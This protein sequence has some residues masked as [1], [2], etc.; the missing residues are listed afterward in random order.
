[1]NDF[2][3]VTSEGGYLGRLHW[4]NTNS[5]GCLDHWGSIF[6]FC[7]NS[8]VSAWAGSVGI[9]RYLLKPLRP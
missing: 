5:T 4:I 7:S 1:M 6:W 9:F 3:R 8:Q 2:F